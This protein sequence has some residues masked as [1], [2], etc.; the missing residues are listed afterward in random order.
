MLRTS[1][2]RHQWRQTTEDVSIVSIKKAFYLQLRQWRQYGQPPA[3]A[4]AKR[5]PE[6]G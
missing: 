5:A 4:R 3:R 6:G 1:Q 2:S